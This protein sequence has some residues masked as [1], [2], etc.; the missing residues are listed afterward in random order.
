MATTTVVVEMESLGEGA[1]TYAEDAN[2]AERAD[3]SPQPLLPLTRESETNSRM[4][5]ENEFRRRA[6]AAVVNGEDRT[7][8]DASEE[9]ISGDERDGKLD[10]KLIR[11]VV[12][13]IVVAPIPTREDSTGWFPRMLGFG[14]TAEKRAYDAEHGYDELRYDNGP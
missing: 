6:G 5:I 9:G 14:K 10:K 7:T 11:G 3:P 8:S 1:T 2:S 12:A 13:N 4:V